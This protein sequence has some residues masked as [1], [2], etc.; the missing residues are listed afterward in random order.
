MNKMVSTADSKWAYPWIE[1]PE[2]LR[3]YA[4][5]DLRFGYMAYTILTGILI[6]DLCPDPEIVCYQLQM[7]QLEA[8]QWLLDWILQTLENLEVHQ[9]A[10]YNARTRRE[11]IC[12]LRYRYNSSSRLSSDP[13]PRNNIWL[14]L[15]GN[16]P[17]L[18]A[19]GCRFI[20]QS[21][22]HFI[23]RKTRISW[24]SGIVLREVT[25]EMLLYA[26]YGFSAIRLRKVDWNVAVS[27]GAPAGLTV[28]P[29]LALPNG[30]HPVMHYSGFLQYSKKNGRVMKFALLHWARTY[31]GE[32]TD[33]LKNV[34]SDQFFRRFYQNCYDAIRFLYR[35]IFNIHAMRVC[36]VEE[37][38]T[39]DMLEQLK[40][41]KAEKTIA[42]EEMKIQDERV[43]HLQMMVDSQDSVERARW[44]EY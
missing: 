4:L 39:G 8:V 29:G 26:L 30:V 32:I 42:E 37:K 6:A 19:G 20:V 1:I 7:Y 36:I 44:R 43:A 16:W 40:V 11:L 17:S 22:E 13:P 25:E 12:A 24:G 21:R 10:V 18:T 23:L 15:L 2:S 3:I 31:P 9:D 5:A 34:K 27:K 33:F 28:H 38:L 35:R 41:A 14:E